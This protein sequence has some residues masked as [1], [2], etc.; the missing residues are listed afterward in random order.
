MKKEL[1]NV[2]KQNLQWN[3]LVAFNTS[4]LI[5]KA[6]PNQILLNGRCASLIRALNIENNWV[7]INNEAIAVARRGASKACRATP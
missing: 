1:K 5:R 3:P 4:A 7:L 6:K 2:C